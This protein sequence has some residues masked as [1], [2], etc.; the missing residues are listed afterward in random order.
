MN[1]TIKL[2]RLAHSAG[3]PVPAYHNIGDAGFDLRA[4][5][6]ENEPLVLNPGDRALVPCGFAFGIDRRDQEIQI[7]PRSGLALN[8]GV[9]VLNSPGTIDS[10]YTG[11]VKVLLC[12]FGVNQVEFVRGDRI[13]Q[14]VL[15]PI[16][17]A[18]FELADSLDTTDRADGGFGSTGVQ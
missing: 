10:G 5:I 13:A 8:H 12:N 11:E 6:P 15:C 1:R 3:L 9:V 4:A 18:H 17:R 14:A 16:L 2:Q 7:R